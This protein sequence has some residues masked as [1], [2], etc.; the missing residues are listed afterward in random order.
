MFADFKDLIA[1]LNKH[2]A[3]YLVIGGYAVS[4]HAQ[5]RYTKDLD[6]LILPAPKN[7]TAVFAALS[8]FGAPLRTRIKH[9]ADPTPPTRKLTAK[10]FE[11]KSAWYT[12]GNPPVAIDILPDIPGVTFNAAWKNRST[13]VIDE[14][15]GL[16]AHFISR[17]DLIAAKLA[18]GR[19]RDL[20]DV[21]ELRKAAN[22]AARPTSPNSP[23]PRKKP[24]V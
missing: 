21:E 13:R 17:E 8:E 15:S 22:V 7:A 16:T 1:L 5:P 11:D 14:A 6:I 9:D 12:M 4:H 19:P 23:K 3:K 10:D 2:K 18:A 20:A 24:P